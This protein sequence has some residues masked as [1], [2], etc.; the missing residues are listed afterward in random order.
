L[1]NFEQLMF[2]HLMLHR[3]KTP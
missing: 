3:T 1:A 2:S